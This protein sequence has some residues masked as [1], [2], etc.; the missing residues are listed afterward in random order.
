VSAAWPACVR[1]P[2]DTHTGMPWH[3][4]ANERG[5]C[6]MI[7]YVR[8]HPIQTFVC[9]CKPFGC[10]DE[11][12]AHTVRCSMRRLLHVPLH[13]KYGHADMCIGIR[14]HA[15]KTLG[16][17]PRTRAHTST[18]IHTNTHAHA[19]THTCTRV[20][21]YTHLCK[22]TQHTLSQGGYPCWARGLQ[23]MLPLTLTETVCRRARA[24]VARQRLQGAKRVPVLAQEGRLQG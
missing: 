8:Q 5:Q 2:A 18:T 16:T 4:V 15:K 7:T 23:C 19:R 17:R 14:T 12:K 1:G 11:H 13:Q 21:A 3:T 9:M 10:C 20:C 6:S 24:C 22:C